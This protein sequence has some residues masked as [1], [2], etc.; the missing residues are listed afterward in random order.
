MRS[1]LPKVLVAAFVIL[2]GASCLWAAELKEFRA[3]RYVPDASNDGDSFLVGVTERSGKKE[4]R[5]RLYF[6]DCPETTAGSKTDARR[7]REQTRYFGLESASET[8]KFG[9]EA[10]EFTRKALGKPFTMHTSFASAGGRSAG[11]RVYAFIT[12]STGEDLA[13]LLEDKGDITLY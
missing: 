2:L 4:H 1:H 7:V 6:V 11:G 13:R 5:V 8:V 9:A 10:T 3:V 12:T